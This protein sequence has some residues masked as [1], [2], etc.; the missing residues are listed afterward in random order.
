MAEIKCP[1]CQL[2][3]RYDAKP[4]SLAG[5]FWKWHIGF[6][7]GWKHYMNSLEQEERDTIKANYKLAK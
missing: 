7:P 2:L 6:C 5:R 3:A 4:K 1:D